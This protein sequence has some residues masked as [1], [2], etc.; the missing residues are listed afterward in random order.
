MLAHLLT[1]AAADDD[2]TFAS[3]LLDVGITLTPLPLLGYLVWRLYTLLQP[4][5]PLARGEYAEARRGYE[6]MASFWIP[7]T[8]RTSRYNAALCLVLEGRLEDGEAALRE[9]LE[10]PLDAR[11]TYASRS[12]L[13]AVLVLRETSPAEARALLRDAHGDIPTPLG[14]LL[15]AHAHLSLGDRGGAAQ[16]VAEALTLPRAP[17]ERPG[18]K[19]A[20]RFDA[21][22]HASMEAFFRGWYFY[23]VGELGR[24]RADLRAAAGSSLPHVCTQR[25]RALLPAASRPSFGDEP[26]SS[27]SPHELP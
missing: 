9:L 27:L 10:E 15:L 5:F 23:K 3:A 6:R 12:L 2:A 14:A 8:A 16:L 4:R 7:T 22:L 11:L 13:G 21:R 26:P 18:W 19:G 17:R 20:L 24:A 25:A 1:A